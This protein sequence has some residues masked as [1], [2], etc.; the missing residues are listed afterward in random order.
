MTEEI[1]I[2][3]VQ[4]DMESQLELLRRLEW[5]KESATPE[6]QVNVQSQIDLVAQDIRR[7]DS[8]MQ[9]LAGR[10]APKTFT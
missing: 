6:D 2:A 10:P 9:E 3:R 5:E 4:K 7:L 8:I 1:T